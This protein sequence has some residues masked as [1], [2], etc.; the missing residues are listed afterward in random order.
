MFVNK[1]KY[2]LRNTVALIYPLHLNQTVPSEMD[3]GFV[4]ND[5]LDVL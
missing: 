2:R 3:H 4:H 5:Y 1:P